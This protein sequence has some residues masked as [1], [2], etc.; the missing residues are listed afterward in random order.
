MVLTVIMVHRTITGSRGAPTGSPPQHQ[1]QEHSRIKRG[2]HRIA[3]SEPYIAENKVAPIR[4]AN[5][6]NSNIY[7]AAVYGTYS[8][9]N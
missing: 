6:D 2:S 1:K 7:N 8:M 5:S 4:V 9:H 3:S